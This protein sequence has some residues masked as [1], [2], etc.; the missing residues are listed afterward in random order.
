[1]TQT[2]TSQIDLRLDRRRIFIMIGLALLTIVLLLTLG[3]GRDALTAL[4]AA[5]WRFVA[6]AVLIHYSGFAARGWRWQRILATLGH[7]LSYRYV[8]SLLIS[9]WFISALIPARAG[10]LVRIG[11]LRSPQSIQH[12]PVSVP[13]S[14]GSIVL[15]RALDILTILLLGAG[16]GYFVLADIN[17][18]QTPRWI[19]V[20]YGAGIALVVIFGVAILALP[21]ILKWLRELN[22]R[23]LWHKLLDFADELATSLRTLL[24]DPVAALLIL[25]LGIYIWL[26][27]AFL[28]W[29]VLRSLG[30][31]A[32][33][34]SAAFIALTVDVLA[35]VP[36]TPGGI[37]QIETAFAAL[38]ALL[39]L[40]AVNIS[41]TI[42]LTRAISYWTFLIFSGL[43]TFAAGIGQFFSANKSI[44]PPLDTPPLDTPPLDTPPLD[45]AP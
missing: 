18:I 19:L 35:A 17:S 33:F 45:T 42:L 23:S 16:F 27:D 7:R 11:L 6:L 15:E 4:A 26:C 40:P 34:S 31:V 2:Q 10:D 20:S 25:W 43:I 8:T 30:Q 37:G 1:M 39:A 22:S 21:A 24:A 12:N 29:F 5:D 14:I 9:G 3:N 28:L 13:T 41:A 32:P 44:A 38:L 36:L